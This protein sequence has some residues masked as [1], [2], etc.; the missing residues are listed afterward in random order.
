M[1][2]LKFD[3]ALR[4]LFLY[5]LTPLVTRHDPP[6]LAN[7]SAEYH[8]LL[9]RQNMVGPNSLFYGYLV[10]DWQPLQHRYLIARG[11]P[12]LRNQA[13]NALKA[14]ILDLHSFVH[15]LW[16]LRN[17]HL[18]GTSHASRTPFKH[19]HLLAQI[20]KLYKAKPHM[21][22]SDRDVVLDKSLADIRALPT[23]ALRSFYQYTKPL[24]E[25]SVQ[26]ASAFGPTF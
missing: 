1:D 9:D 18:H 6:P 19:L 3:P 4:R 23:N 8:L 20:T 5:F 17:S 2:R 16:L 10:T 21:L 22:A 11:L 13:E 12:S 24:V 26:Q 15:D 14:L 25:R 7:L